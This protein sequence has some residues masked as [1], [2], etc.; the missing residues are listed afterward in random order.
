M[1]IDTLTKR[2]ADINQADDENRTPLHVAVRE[3]RL[4]FVKYLLYKG[5]NIYVRF[6]IILREMSK[7]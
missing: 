1:I 7:Y 5:A 4:P 3:N 2:G 6:E